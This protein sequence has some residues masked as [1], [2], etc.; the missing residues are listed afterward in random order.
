MLIRLLPHQNHPENPNPTVLFA[1]AFQNLPDTLPLPFSWASQLNALS[2]DDLELP[3]S[4]H[5]L[6]KSVV[7]PC[8]IEQVTFDVPAGT[9]SCLLIDGSLETWPL[10]DSRNLL[11]RVINDVNDSA[12]IAEFERERERM[13]QEAHAESLKAEALS[14]VKVKTH[15]KQRSLLMSLVASIVSPTSPSPSPPPLKPIRD[16]VP[17]PASAPAPSLKPRA[18]RR[19]ARS[20]LVDAF[21]LYVQPEMNNRMPAGGFYTW[22]IH[23]M[24]RRASAQRDHLIKSAGVKSF[25]LVPDPSYCPP[26][27]LNPGLEDDDWDDND[28]D[29]SSIRTPSSLYSHNSINRH[30]ADWKSLS[31]SL[32]RPSPGNPFSQEV[33]ECKALS[34][35]CLR[36]R[37]LIIVANARQVHADRE[38]KQ[39]ES[40]LEI[41]SRRRAWLNKSLVGSGHS[42]HDFGFA[43]PFKTS[44]LGQTSWS[45][46]DYEYVGHY[47]ENMGDFE[48]YEDY[49]EKLVFGLKPTRSSNDATRLFSVREEHE[50]DASG[51]EIELHGD[52]QRDEE[53]DEDEDEVLQANIYEAR[54]EKFGSV[55]AKGLRVDS[56]GAVPPSSSSLLCEPLTQFD[57]PAYHRI[58]DSS[59]FTL[60]MDLPFSVRIDDQR[61]LAKSKTLPMSV[62]D[63]SARAWLR[64]PV[65]VDCR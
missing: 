49:E 3:T 47:D 48:E 57:P 36:L 40:M 21:R 56:V 52:W 51:Y 5:S 58:A 43:M 8:I 25:N 20:T 12:A 65:A 24:L 62:I 15:K 32:S 18:L 26:P 34:A 50:T 53:D 61:T 35:T 27:V 42:S 30:S 7:L 44:R 11:D 10:C 23:S 39:K 41:R 54:T 22:I 19:R 13:R 2:M 4:V 16:V 37:H 59:E 46:N 63:R 60:S 1:V 31:E 6:D 28:T 17:V 9:I 45:G 14:S 55:L 29:G 64:Q 33:A 38:I